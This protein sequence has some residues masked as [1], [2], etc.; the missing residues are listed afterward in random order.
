MTSASQQIKVATVAEKF[1]T[2]PEFLLLSPRKHWTINITR[3]RTVRKKLATV[4]TFD[5]V[6]TQDGLE[7][8]GARLLGYMVRTSTVFRHRVGISEASNADLGSLKT[9]FIDAKQFGAFDALASVAERGRRD[10]KWRLI[11]P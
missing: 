1:R 10:R 5:A 7:F 4:A 9:V 6:T 8:Q 3:V 11:N 2:G